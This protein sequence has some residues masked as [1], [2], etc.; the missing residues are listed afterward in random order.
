MAFWDQLTENK[1]GLASQP[2][3]KVEMNPLEKIQDCIDDARDNWRANDGGLTMAARDLIDIG[4]ATIEAIKTGKTG[5]FLPEDIW[6]TDTG[7]EQDII[8]AYLEWEKMEESYV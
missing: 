8:L 7:H 3:G 2:G 6:N 5:Y 4:N 1:A